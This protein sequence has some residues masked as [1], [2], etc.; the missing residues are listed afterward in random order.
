MAIS[1]QRTHNRQSVIKARNRATST[2]VR[3]RERSHDTPWRL[4]NPFYPY[5]ISEETEGTLFKGE[6][7]LGKVVLPLCGGNVEYSYKL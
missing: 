5:S 4:Y 6:G 3:E 2:E 7:Y 1:Y